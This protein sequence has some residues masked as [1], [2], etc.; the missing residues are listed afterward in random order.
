MCVCVCVCVCLYI[1]KYKI[2]LIIKHNMSYH[3]PKS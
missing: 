3:S 2:E 1:N